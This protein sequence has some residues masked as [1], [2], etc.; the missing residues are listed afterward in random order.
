MKNTLIM[1][2]ILSGKILSAQNLTQTVKGV[3][4]DKISEKPLQ[5]AVIT[6]AEKKAISNNNGNYV[7]KNIAIGRITISITITG[8][9]PVVI[10]EV[11]VTTGKE[12]VVD[13]ALEQ[14]VKV[15]ADVTVS[16]SKTKK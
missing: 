8:Y 3:I 9:K 14:D 10:P 7:L 2:L 4:T 15:L 1:L 16:S 13:V 6:I 11:L 12:V 5:G